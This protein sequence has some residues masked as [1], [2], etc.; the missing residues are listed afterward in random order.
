MTDKD[1]IS[2]DSAVIVKIMELLGSFDEILVI[3]TSSGR[4]LFASSAAKEFF[5]S[6]IT[7]RNIND[8]I[9]DNSASI[10]ISQGFCGNPITLHTEYSGSRLTLSMLPCIGYLV[11]TAVPSPG[12]GFKETRAEFSF[13]AGCELRDALSSLFS[14]FSVLSSKGLT[15]EKRSKSLGVV[16]RNLHRL[17]RLTNN[18][19]DLGRSLTDEWSLNPSSSDISAFCKDIADTLIPHCRARG[20]TLVTECPDYPIV[21]DFDKEKLE[22]AI[23][24]IFSNSMLNTKENGLISLHLKK[25]GNNIIIRIFDNGCG[26]PEAELP[27][28]FSH[29]SAPPAM[30]LGKRFGAGFGLAVAK[31][32]MTLHGGSI[33]LE[34][35]ENEG[36]T[37]TLSL[38]CGLPKGTSAVLPQT[39][40][41]GGF[42]PLLLELS[43]V[44]DS[45]EYIV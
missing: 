28:A 11:I 32:V 40:S 24:N 25:Q 36:T 26:I 12:A 33:M 3:T 15:E 34:S 38:C 13:Y 42:S 4:I 10:L 31:A 21:C 2:R 6:D 17:L 43:S 1:S 39:V 30:A 37:V 45:R 22:R 7:G 35:S 41:S 9:D 19:S 20:I 5:L 27:F 8:I 14:A 29:Y 18:M 16:N 44:L 23:L